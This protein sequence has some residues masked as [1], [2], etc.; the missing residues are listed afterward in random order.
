MELI[1]SQIGLIVEQKCTTFLLEHGFTVLHPLGNFD[2]YDIC[3]EKNG[4]FYRIQCKHANLMETG[5]KLR[6]N[7]QSRNG[8]RRGYTKEDCDFFMTEAYGKFYLFPVWSAL[9]KKVWTVPSG[10]PVHTCCYAKDFL[11]E[12][13]LKTL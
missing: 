4:I 3:I 13:V 11:A 12:E 10:N 9:E 1:S 6:T 7:I 2:K 8:K 5:F